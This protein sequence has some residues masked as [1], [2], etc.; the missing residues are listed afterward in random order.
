VDL[1]ADLDCR[2]DTDT[3][4]NGGIDLDEGL[5]CRFKDIETG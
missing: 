2:I 1:D 3:D 5:D 4:L